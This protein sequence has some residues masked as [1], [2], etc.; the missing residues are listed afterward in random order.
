VLRM[1]KQPAEGDA[2]WAIKV[3]ALCRDNGVSALLTGS[4]ASARR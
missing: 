2:P 1:P 4:T 3:A